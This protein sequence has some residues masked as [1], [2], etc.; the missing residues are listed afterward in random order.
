MITIDGSR[1]EGGGQILRNAMSYAALFQQSLRIHSVRAQKN[2]PGLRAQHKCSLDIAA[3]ICGGGLIGANIGSHSFDF[4]PISSSECRFR[5]QECKEKLVID[6]GTAGSICLLLQVAL[7]CWV[8]NSS[9]VKLLE[10]RGGTNASL[11]PQIDYMLN[12]FL[13]IISRQ[14]FG[15]IVAQIDVQTRG[16]YPIGKGIVQCLLNPI[17]ETFQGPLQPIILMERG[18]VVSISI[19]CFYAGKV[20]R[21]VACRMGNAASNYIQKAL[22]PSP[23]QPTIEIIKH[24]PA[25]GSASGILIIAKTD[26]NCIFGASALGSRSEKPERTV[27]KAAQELLDSLNSGGCVDAWLQDQLIIFMALAQGESKIRTGCL[28]LHTRTAIDVACQMTKAAFEIV[29][30]DSAGQDDS[31]SSNH[32]VMKDDDD[33]NKY[34]EKGCIPG[35]HIIIC[36]GVGLRKEDTTKQKENE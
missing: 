10:L 15:Y 2:P 26:T 22:N 28:T 18:H 25:I 20:P 6:I 21:F 16:Y 9:R 29:K 27:E 24:E 3:E 4:H 12:V 23:V 14:C 36:Q 30:I 8:F 31:S 7:P 13:P 34:G 11:A 35:Q 5:K 33:A 17:L 1:G 19:Q 32:V